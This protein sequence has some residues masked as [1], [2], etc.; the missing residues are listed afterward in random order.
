MLTIHATQIP[1]VTEKERQT[2]TGPGAG[3]V[4]EGEMVIEGCREKRGTEMQEYK[5][6]ELLYTTRSMKGA[7][8]A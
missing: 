4:T 1:A 6:T 5:N 3:T 7:P 2:D 8:S